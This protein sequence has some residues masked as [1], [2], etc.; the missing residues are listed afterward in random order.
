MKAIWLENA[1]WLWNGGR[2]TS[3]NSALKCFIWQSLIALILKKGPFNTDKFSLIIHIT[4]KL[5]KKKHTH[6]ANVGFNNMSTK[7]DFQ[8][9]FLI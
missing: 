2:N 7:P 6:I 4:R 1:G 8:E 5:P 3:V 9:L